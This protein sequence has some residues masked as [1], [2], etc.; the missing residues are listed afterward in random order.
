MYPK[1]S[2]VTPSFNQASYLETTIQSV[3]GQGYPN[4][5]YIII[6]GGSTDGSVD[7][8]K[9]Y[10]KYITYWV[11]EPDKGQSHALN[12][13][14]EKCTGDIFNWINSDDYFEPGALQ[15]IAEVFCNNPDALQVCGYTR[16]F[17]DISNR[18]IQLHRCEI[19]DSAEKTIVQERINQQGL[20]YK[21]SVI[22]ELGFINSTLNYVMDLELWIRYLCSYGI[23]KIV[24][25]D[26]L[27]GNFR[28]HPGSKT[29]DF[30]ERFRNEVSGI[31]YHILYQ[32]NSRHPC[33]NHFKYNICYQTGKWDTKAIKKDK[34]IFE[35]SRRY[36]YDFY[37]TKNKAACRRT[38]PSLLLQGVLPLNRH[39]MKIFLNSFGI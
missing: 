39:T 29:H 24:L 22:R 31:F 34:F 26:D 23:G 38:F 14:L 1:L 10:E 28:I 36:F 8:I 30:E 27:I 25:I 33:V 32:F 20:F 9:K 3:I 18:T 12:K 6:D 5:E 13:G 16:I 19:F 21:L 2:I 35:L 37:K 7:I 17:E 11:S 15:K 4:L